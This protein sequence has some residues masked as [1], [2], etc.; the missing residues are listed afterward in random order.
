[1]AMHADLMVFNARYSIQPLI[2]FG[3]LFRSDE[4]TSAPE[5][6]AKNIIILKRF[7]LGR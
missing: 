1:M 6:D 2:Q 5:I 4:M 7:F 3:L